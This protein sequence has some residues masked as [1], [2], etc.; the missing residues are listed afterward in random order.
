MKKTLLICL[1]AVAVA[2][3]KKP[4]LENNY[5]ER[6]YTEKDYPFIMSNPFYGGDL[7]DVA[8]ISEEDIITNPYGT[9]TKLYIIF[10]PQ[11]Y[12]SYDSI[13]S[14]YI[15][16]LYYNYGGLGEYD[17]SLQLLSSVK[18]IFNDTHIKFSDTKL[19][20]MILYT[21]LNYTPF[22]K[23]KEYPYTINGNTLVINGIKFI[24]MAGN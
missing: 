20:D 11:Y 23:E 12:F 8:Y 5:P 3:C 6:I 15:E 1:M 21:D 13:T 24:N 22:F 14:Q 9:K 4:T 18:Y 17:I 7:R 2:A 19:S 16:T 10:F